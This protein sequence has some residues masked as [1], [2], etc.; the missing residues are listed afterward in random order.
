MYKHR[1]PRLHVVYAYSFLLYKKKTPGRM[2]EPKRKKNENS[3][4]S[5][6]F[7]SLSYRRR[8]NNKNSYIFV[9]LLFATYQMGTN[10]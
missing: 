3:V 2:E 1:L 10:V 8:R 9:L 4:T 6:L 7:S 5:V